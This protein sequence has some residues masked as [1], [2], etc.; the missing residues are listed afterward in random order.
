[1]L[2]IRD[3]NY[4]TKKDNFSLFLILFYIGVICFR[5]ETSRKAKQ[6]ENLEHNSSLLIMQTFILS[7][8]EAPTL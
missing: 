7:V 1:M 6:L 3:E 2:I 8:A 4:D 5:I